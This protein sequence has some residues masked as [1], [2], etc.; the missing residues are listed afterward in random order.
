[1]GIIK[2]FFLIAILGLAVYLG[3]SKANQYINRV[4]ELVSIRS[5]KNCD[6]ILK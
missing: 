3:N 4:K 2:T 5:D 1:M 6:E